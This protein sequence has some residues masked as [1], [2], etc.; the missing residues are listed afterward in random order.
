MGFYIEMTTPFGQA[1]LVEQTEH[2]THL[3]FEKE[4]LNGMIKKDQELK[5]KKTALLQKAKQQLEEY[6]RGERTTFTLPMHQEGTDFQ[7][8]VWKALQTIPYGESR[9]YSDIARE[10]GQPKAVRAI[11][12][13]N[14]KN[15]LPIFIPCH[16]VI[17]K[18]KTLTGY[19]GNEIDK[20]A[21]LLE[22][23]KIP[24]KGK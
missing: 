14:K 7:K 2:I 24:Y 13:A 8:K 15:A 9:S 18:N 4:E 6:F 17:G 19:A 5:Q 12:Q 10:I 11:G 23:E 1:Y 16:R 22:I 20:K 21:I 3:L